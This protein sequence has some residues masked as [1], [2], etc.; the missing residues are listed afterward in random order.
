MGIAMS[1]NEQSKSDSPQLLFIS[2]QAK[3]RW[4]F[5]IIYKNPLRF[6]LELKKGSK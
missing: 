2:R 4:I 6:L 1:I 5:L 3:K